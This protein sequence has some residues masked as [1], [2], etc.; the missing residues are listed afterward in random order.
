LR[1]KGSEKAGAGGFQRD[2]E[3]PGNLLVGNTERENGWNRVS[4]SSQREQAEGKLTATAHPNARVEE[5]PVTSSASRE[6]EAQKEGT[7]LLKMKAGLGRGWAK[8]W[9]AC[10]YCL[11][12][13]KW[14]YQCCWVWG[15]PRISFE[16][17]GIKNQWQRLF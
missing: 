10:F 15:Q 5:N 1:L 12:T 13:S 16:D 17:G 14:S 9:K 8:Q 3:T 7:G 11:G 2:L 4:A 6:T